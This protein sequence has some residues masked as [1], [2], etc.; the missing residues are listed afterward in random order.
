M[1]TSSHSVSLCLA[2]LKAGVEK[3]KN[4][5]KLLGRIWDLYEKRVQRLAASRLSEH[6]RRLLYDEDIVGM[7]FLKFYRGV[8]A[9]QFEKLDT[10]EDVF[11]LLGLIT[12]SL[13]RDRRRYWLGKKLGGPGRGQQ[14]ANEKP[15]ARIATMSLAALQV[16]LSTRE[17]DLEFKVILEEFVGSLP[18][19]LRETARLL[20]AGEDIGDIA[21]RR[22]CVP[23]TIQRYRHEIM[24]HWEKEA[25]E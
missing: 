2:G 17:P 20:M 9:A 8:A 1:D 4:L 14:S 3:E 5:A 22:G 18:E 19:H 12:V 11:E 10:R 15:A 21:A 23:R 6:D 24:L 25:R 13:V 7:V 16:E